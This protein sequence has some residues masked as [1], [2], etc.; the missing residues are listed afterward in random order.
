MHLQQHS[1][2]ILIFCWSVSFWNTSTIK[3]LPSYWIKYFL[4]YHYNHRWFYN[5]QYLP[6]NYLIAY[7]YRSSKYLPFLS[8]N[9]PK[10]KLQLFSSKIITWKLFWFPEFDARSSQISSFNKKKTS[11][12]FEIIDRSTK[13]CFTYFV[14]V[15]KKFWQAD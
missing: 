7:C 11:I 13:A 8:W 15:W 12:P 10:E 2:F 14:T 4:Q 6:H 3:V 5:M 9:I 1:D